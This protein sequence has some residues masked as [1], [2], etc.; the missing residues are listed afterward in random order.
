MNTLH[1]VIVQNALK[2]LL[3][4][5]KFGNGSFQLTRKIEL[6]H[7]EVTVACLNFLIVGY[8]WAEEKLCMSHPTIE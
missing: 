1:A 8:S 5:L 2:T 4:L 6:L 3:R 7:N